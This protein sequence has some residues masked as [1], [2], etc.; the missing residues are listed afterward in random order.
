MSAFVDGFCLNSILTMYES[1]RGVGGIIVPTTF[2]QRS[3]N[4][5]TTFPQPVNK[6][7]K[8]T[9]YSS[10]VSIAPVVSD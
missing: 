10:S 4:V 6:S 1:R 3:H 2:P 8:L 5:P 9:L 7:V